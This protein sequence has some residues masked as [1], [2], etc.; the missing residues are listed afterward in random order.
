MKK[1]A[2]SVLAGMVL[3]GVMM[4]SQANAEE[5][6]GEAVYNRAC[7]ACH[8]FGAAGAPIT[9]NASS[10]QNAMEKGVDALYL[11][12]IQGIGAMPPKGGQSSLP[13]EEVKAAVDYML[14]K[15]S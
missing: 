11:N 13:D 6:D 3:G 15:S 12:A 7:M 14:D 10:W 2:K 5:V 9:G 8:A 4:A 1:L